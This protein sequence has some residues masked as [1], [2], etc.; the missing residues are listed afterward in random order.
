MV[1]SRLKALAFSLDG[2]YFDS[3]TLV[4]V[5][6]FH[7]VDPVVCPPYINTVRATKVGTYTQVRNRLDSCMRVCTYRE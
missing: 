1:M 4:A 3:N 5:G 6:D 2:T 7:V